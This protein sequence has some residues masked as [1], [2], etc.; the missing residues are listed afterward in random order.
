[1]ANMVAGY[2]WLPHRGCSKILHGPALSVRYRS[3][4]CGGWIGRV[5]YAVGETDVPTHVRSHAAATYLH[6]VHL[7]VDDV[8]VGRVHLRRRVVCC[9]YAAWGG[10][11]VQRW[12]GALGRTGRP[13]HGSTH[14]AQASSLRPPPP[15]PARS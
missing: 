1:V 14:V 9:G 8:L 13:E 7:G 5:G 2:T 15:A 12:C 4:N 11:A 6:G 10:R 3:S